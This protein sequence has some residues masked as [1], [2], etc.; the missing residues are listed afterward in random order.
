MFK[1]TYQGGQA[2][3]KYVQEGQKRMFKLFDTDGTQVNDLSYYQKIGAS[4]PLIRE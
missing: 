4:I 2:S 3:N 1:L